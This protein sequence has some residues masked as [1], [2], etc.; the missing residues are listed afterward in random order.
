M[1][2]IV[3]KNGAGNTTIVQKSEF[4]QE[5]KLQQY[6]H[7]HPEAIPVYDIQTDKRLFV[8]AREF[9]TESGAIDAL[10][11]DGDGDIYIVETKLHANPDKRRVV[12]QVLDYGASLWRHF[13]SFDKFL[14]S[15]NQHTQAKWQCDFQRKVREVYGIED[16]EAEE[17]LGSM[18]ANLKSGNLKFVVL[19]D[20]MDE[21][22]K[23][24]I[25]YI[26]QK[27]Q[28]DIYGVELEYYKHDEYEIAIPK[29]YGVE[30]KKDVSSSPMPTKWSW[31]S[32]RDDAAK[33]GLEEPAIAAMESLKTSCESF[34]SLVVFWGRGR[35]LG[36][37]NIK[38][39]SVSS[40]SF[41]SMTSD[42]RLWF[43]F[44]NFRSSDTADAAAI[45]RDRLKEFV[46]GKLGLSVPDDYQRRFP[47]F[48]VSTWLP[49]LNLLEDGI[50]ELF[51]GKAASA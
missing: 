39:P 8:A 46:T 23:D 37:Y 10:A 9:S 4:G 14:S 24:L 11:V 43:N 28:F 1:A 47:N 2:I 19:M 33:R 5:L 45:L 40:Q 27:S 35:E 30:V 26:N 22:L 13:G 12:A 15:L 49:K 16:N 41:I 38:A 3:S 21:R 32:F 17:L 36:S 18:E 29:I 34:S 6:I 51:A 20:S 31:Q 25:T 42:G 44:G 7:D 50:R 48:P